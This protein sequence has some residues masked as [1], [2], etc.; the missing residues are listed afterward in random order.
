MTAPL[1]TVST[2]NGA[3][4]GRNRG[5]STAFYGVPYAEPPVGARTF[6]PPTP[7]SP[8][9]GVRDATTPTATA[10]HQGFDGGT[11]PE[12]SVSGDDI[13]TVN[14]FTPDPS[15]HA[16]LPVLVWIHGGA[17]IAG[18][19]ISPWYDGASFNRHGIV[20]VTVGY[21]LGV[22]GFG[23]VEDAPANR[24]VLDWLAA[25]HWVQE[26]IAAFG[27]DPRRV[28]IAGQ[29]AGGEAVLTLLGIN[30]IDSLAHQAIAMSPVMGLATVSDASRTIAEIGDLL[31]VPP[32]ASA[33]AN[34]DRVALAD[35]PWRMRNVFGA[36]PGRPGAGADLV[37]LVRDVLTSLELAPTLHGD[38]VKHPVVT[39]AHDGPGR[40]IPLMIGSVAQELN[41]MVSSPYHDNDPNHVDLESLGLS[42]EAISEY[43]SQRPSLRID[44]LLGQLLSD[45]LIRTSVP[46]VAEGRAH[47][48]VYDFL[49]PAQGLLDQGK[50]YHCIDIPF[51]WGVTATPE[52]RRVV[53]D[54]PKSLAHEVHNAWVRFIT[55]GDPGWPTY[56]ADR[57]VQCF[58]TI[59][60]LSADGYAAERVLLRKRAEVEA[61]GL[62]ELASTPPRH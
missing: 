36:A 31:G 59:T 15:R 52:A 24:G 14:I 62:R 2:P 4:R 51:A 47:T 6:A 58:D 29:S 44:A 8:W 16:S 56:D 35:V 9:R 28:T 42:P 33:L 30:G 5:E 19:P 48:W 61:T 13:L 1:V 57:S 32:T 39:G 41:D 27:G 46:A 49:W 12:P 45:L 17:F 21:R 25:L 54:A 53:G 50:A 22:T 7:R 60:A 3:V 37:R 11:I 20:V 38:T 26:N 43:L 18:S 40:A 10:Q 55:D 34:V 23:F